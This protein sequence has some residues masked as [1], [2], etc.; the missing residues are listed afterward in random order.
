[1]SDTLG[2]SNELDLSKYVAALWRWWWVILG[3]AIL[4]ALIAFAFT[5]TQAVS[6]RAEAD[7]AIIRTG[8]VVNLDNR[9][10]TISDTDPNAQSVDQLARRRSLLTIGNSDDLAAAVMQTLGS[11]LPADINTPESV[12]SHVQVTSDSDVIAIQATMR[13]P[14]QAAQLANAYA[15]AYAQRVNT[16]LGDAAF[17]TA[18]LHA[19]TEQAKQAYDEKQTALTTF[20]A[21]SPIESLKRQVDLLGGQLDAQV[22]I[23]NKL[24]QLEQD[25][26][27]LRDRVAN[28]SDH[29]L[30]GA[31]LAQLLLEANAFN[32]G[33]NASSTL[34]SV[35]LSTAGLNLSNL[36]AAEQTKSLDDLIRAIRA[37]RSAQSADAQQTLYK[38]LT[39]AQ[40]QLEQ[41][42]AQLKELQAARD[43]AWNAFQLV[44]TKEQEAA[45]SSGYPNEI[46]RIINSASVPDAPLPSR[47]SLAMLIGAALGIIVGI[48]LAF[49]LDWLRLGRKQTA[50]PE[51]VVAAQGASRP[52]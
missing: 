49:L 35:Q 2:S 52:K 12:R 23:Q 45:V 51:A 36:T 39:T 41:A 14:E 21:A 33:T 48:A 4:G 28:G 15:Q 30:A 42:Q 47:R 9:A 8:T 1:M 11:Q 5:T 37:R 46:V 32:N 24:I 26:Q 10:R 3:A 22:Q 31:Q 29:A 43:L 38:Q 7:L 50:Q 20:L 16:L 44:A 25:A 19:Q 17:S 18:A 27:A 34:P 13:T 40:A 6:F